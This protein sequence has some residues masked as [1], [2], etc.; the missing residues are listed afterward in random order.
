MTKNAVAKSWQWASGATGTGGT[1]NSNELG[2]PAAPDLPV[3]T[4]RSTTTLTVEFVA[5]P[6]AVSSEYRY[7]FA[8][9]AP[10]SFGA[11]SA[12]TA[13]TSV[14]L[15][16]LTGLTLN[17][18]YEVQARSTNAVGTS[19]WSNTARA[20]THFSVSKA[21]DVEGVPYPTDANA[22]LTTNAGFAAWAIDPYLTEAPAAPA[23]WP[24]AESAGSY[25]I[26]NTDPA[27]TDTANTYGYPDKPRLT[28]PATTSLA[29][30]TYI[31]IGP[32]G[33]YDNPT[34]RNFAG[35]IGTSGSPIWFRG[36][37]PKNPPKFTG[38]PLLFENTSWIFVENFKWDGGNLINTVMQTAFNGSG[39]TDHLV[40][41]ALE[42]T[43]L[44]FIAGGAGV[45]S[46]SSDN[47]GARQTTD[48]IVY[49]CNIHNNDA[50]VDWTA[51]DADHHGIAV[52]TRTDGLAQTNLTSLIWN[53]DNRLEVISG[54]GIQIISIPSSTPTDERDIINYVWS[55]GNRTGQSRQAGLWSKRASHILFI[56]NEVSDSKPIYF[57]GNGQSA[58]CQYGP[59]NLW[60]IRNR[61]DD[62][63][64]GIMQTDT[65]T[66]DPEP[67]QDGRFYIL[68][69]ILSGLYNSLN[70]TD[71]FRDG[72]AVSFTFHGNMERYSFNN[73]IYDCV[74][75]FT[76]NGD[77]KRYEQNNIIS[78][79]D[80]S[81]GFASDS[82]EFEQ[83][84]GSA[85]SNSGGDLQLYFRQDGGKLWDWA[86]TDYTTLATFQT[87]TS[88][89]FV[90]GIEGDPLFEDIANG[91]VRLKAG[92]PGLVTPDLIAAD[93][94]A[95]YTIFNT[96]YGI[97]LTAPINLGAKEQV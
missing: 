69:N 55:A 85:T 40:L 64:Y 29:A 38:D 39:D 14:E 24:S 50:N 71:S 25:F 62:A 15:A 70:Q 2:A 20:R 60:Y 96:L 80:G 76:G 59:D 95:P 82:G 53:M 75:G 74:N 48:I 1:Y 52:S 81:S 54:N 23:P 9:D 97:T 16:D 33:T 10:Q 22:T 26:D 32:G 46:I 5:D 93:S 91:D 47:R 34:E 13:A 89:A 19:D 67:T 41:R 88:G 78:L 66:P 28:I 51:V 30:G 61:M 90:N 63:A 77:G 56:E 65:S 3:I 68:E 83:L 42:C 11:W 17:S 27:A 94:T 57:A 43:N 79:R 92:S 7:R 21:W 72:T 6:I 73:T 49:D 37:S 44:D 87:A 4:G 31:E 8:N 84:Y 12:A 45:L 35:S 86:T 18:F 36:S 58:G